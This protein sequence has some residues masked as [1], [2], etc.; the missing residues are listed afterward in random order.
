MERTAESIINDLKVI[1]KARKPLDRGLWLESAFYLS[2]LREDE[3]RKLNRLNQEVS[4]LKLEKIAAQEGK[5]NDSLA[6][7]EI[8]ATDKYV[9]MKD[10]EA[11]ITT[12]DELIRVSKKNAESSY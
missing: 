6:Q 8:E 12:M 4:K 10:Q 2:L 5:K 9:E 1:V 11:R 7:S 3:A